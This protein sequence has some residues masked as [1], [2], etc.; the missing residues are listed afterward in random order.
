MVA[1]SEQ[2]RWELTWSLQGHAARTLCYVEGQL[3]RGESAMAKRA[4]RKTARNKKIAAMKISLRTMLPR[5]LK[6]TG[7]P[8]EQ[9]LNSTIGH[10]TDYVIDLK[11][12]VILSPDHYVALWTEGFKT[13]I[14]NGGADGFGEL[15]AMVK[16]S[17]ALKKYL[18]TFLRRSY[19]KHYDELYKKRPQVEEAELWIGQNHADYGLLVAPRFVGGDWEND[20]S[21][22]RH[23][24]PRYWTIGHVLSTGLVV[25]GKKAVI[26]FADV[27]AY[28][29]FFEH[30]LVRGTASSHQHGIASLYSDFVR[31]SSTPENIPLLIPELRYDGRA[32]KH[33]YRLDF[34]VLDAET[35]SKVGFELS[36]WSSHGLITGTKSKSQHEINEEAK[37]NFEKEMRKHKNFY[38]KHG[39]FAL[40]YTDSDLAKPDEI[41]ADIQACLEPREPGKQL[42]FNMIEDLFK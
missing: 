34:C 21:E 5:V 27:D 38:K 9:S 13:H 11:N 10:K 25:P 16:A 4:P 29:T 12:E 7:I 14:E 24:K 1:M 23:F 33:K 42:S 36:P 3:R 28:L 18:D 2:Q 39:V 22:I 26:P 6:E 19:L 41:F 8:D 32:A 30:V 31:C 37:A 20:E 35:M 40:I 17:P 15:F